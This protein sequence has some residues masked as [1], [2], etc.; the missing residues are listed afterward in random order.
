MSGLTKKS[1]HY[2]DEIKISIFFVAGDNVEFYSIRVFKRFANIQPGKFLIIQFGKLC[3]NLK[4]M[5]NLP[6]NRRNH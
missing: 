5:F 3:E 6:T 1:I 4:K 2:Y